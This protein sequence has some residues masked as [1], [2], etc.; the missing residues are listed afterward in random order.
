M[1][2]RGRALAPQV[3][4]HILHLLHAVIAGVKQV[5]RTFLLSGR[6]DAVDLRADDDAGQDGDVTVADCLT[7]RHGPHTQ[8]IIE[9][10]KGIERVQ[11]V[12]SRWRS[13]ADGRPHAKGYRPANREV[14]EMH[15]VDAARQRDK[16]GF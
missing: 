8:A 16:I 12:F 6:R 4:I 11:K 13:K 14:A 10:A 3:A 1:V 7:V 5:C 9:G 2:T 15:E